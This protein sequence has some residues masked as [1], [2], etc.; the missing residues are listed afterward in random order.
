MSP[1]LVIAII[2]LALSTTAGY[3]YRRAR[4]T[5][6]PEL[7]LVAL[8]LWALETKAIAARDRARNRPRAIQRRALTSLDEV[9]TSSSCTSAIDRQPSAATS[10]SSP[11]TVN[12]D[13]NCPT[14][15][16]VVHYVIVRADLPHGSQVAQTVHAAGESTPARTLPGTI[17]VALHA[18]DAQHLATVGDALD[19]AGI[20][21]HRV[22]E[23]DGELMAIGVE[24]TTA[25][26][27]VR[28]V[29]SK[30][31]LVK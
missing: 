24:P 14:H 11:G 2:V 21:N 27:A 26:A 30:L 1:E 4:R 6:Q 9:A 15:L 17:A 10:S 19:A 22:L 28:K 16:E 18:R 5:N 20:P 7:A 8:M 31:P 12:L 23:C 25:R 29:L 13:A 3:L